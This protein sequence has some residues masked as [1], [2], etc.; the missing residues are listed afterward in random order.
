MICV[1]P[2][3]RIDTPPYSPAESIRPS[4]LISITLG[5]SGSGSQ[6]DHLYTTTVINVVSKLTRKMMVLT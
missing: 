5:N 6:E 4:G 3:Q 2:S 1:R